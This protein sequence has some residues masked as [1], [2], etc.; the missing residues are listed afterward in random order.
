MNAAFDKSLFLEPFLQL[1]LLSRM[2]QINPEFEA[3][4]H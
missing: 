2:L 4:F 1:R 3:D